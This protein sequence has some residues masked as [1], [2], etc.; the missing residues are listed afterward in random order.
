[1]LQSLHIENIALIKNLDIEFPES[2]SCFT[3]VTGA[4]KSILIDS[5]SLL[6]GEKAS[7]ELIRNG[8]KCAKVEGIFSDISDSSLDKCK[9]FDIFPDDDG[10]IYISRTVTTDGKNTVKINSKPCPLSLLREIAPFLINIHGQHT[11]QEL[12]IKEKH[13]SIL[14]SFA[15]NDQLLFDYKAQFSKYVSLKKEYD[16]INTDETHNAREIEILKFQ[17]NDISTLKLKPGEDDALESER[18]R[19]SN[20]EKISTSAKIVYESL[21]GESSGISALDNVNTALESLKN[22]TKYADNMETLLEKLESIKSEIV[23]I[24]ETVNDLTGDSGENPTIKID[25]IQTRLDDI[26]K[27]KKKYGGDIESV[28]KF[29]DDAKQKL[30]LLENSSSI[31]EE[32]LEKLKICATKVKASAKMLHESRMNAATKLS[33]LIE[34]EFIYLDMPKVKFKVE[35]KE[36][37]FSNDG[38]DDI[39]FFIQTNAGDGFHPLC[40]IASGGE[41]SRIMLAIKCVTAQKDGIDTMIFDEI[42]TGISGK[43]SRKIGEKLLQISKDRQVLCV[44]HSAQIASL[45]TSHF[46]VSKSEDK[47][48]FTN[49]VVKQL[50]DDERIEETARII[51]GINIT[52]AARKAA[53]ELMSK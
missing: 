11:S 49:T 53:I 39:E 13:K 41:M 21:Y 40:K 45:S 38:C 24:A 46:L 16:S 29:L 33:K 42:D 34:D 36:K 4:G 19:L 48:G 7:K 23:D 27:A 18:K 28:L 5:I 43:T 30:N 1:M 9:D 31:K 35:I 37:P 14:D 20:I 22:L 6:C 32:I 26:A 12:L 8:E 10:V 2:F 15:E 47:D 25:R 17:I 3:G 51:A 50:S 52:D 44:T